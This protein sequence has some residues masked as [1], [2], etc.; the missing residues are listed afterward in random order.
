[1]KNLRISHV[2][3]RSQTDA[4][5]APYV[6]KKTFDERIIPA[7]RQMDALLTQLADFLRPLL[8]QLMRHN[9]VQ[10]NNAAHV[11]LGQIEL[12]LK[13]DGKPPGVPSNVWYPLIKKTH[14]LMYV[15]D[16]LLTYGLGTANSILREYAGIERMD[17]PPL[18]KM[19]EEDAGFRGVRL[20][21]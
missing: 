11:K 19:H 13:G 21:F 16:Q 15:Y 18:K 10:S 12:R 7:P 4:D 17:R 6:F 20:M 14:A 5:V 1:M 2:E 9:V 8:Q 3:Y